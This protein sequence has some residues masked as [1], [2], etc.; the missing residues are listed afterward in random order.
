MKYEL[1]WWFDI[2]LGNCMGVGSN[3]GRPKWNSIF[4]IFDFDLKLKG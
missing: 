2:D 3:L 1:V 4:F